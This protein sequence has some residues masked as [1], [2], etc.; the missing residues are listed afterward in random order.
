MINIF[1]IAGY[2]YGYCGEAFS[3]DPANNAPHAESEREDII[4][5]ERSK[6]YEC[7]G[8]PIV[9][10]AAFLSSKPCIIPFNIASFESE[11][12]VDMIGGTTKGSAIWLIKV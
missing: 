2:S 12:M 5:K 7:R 4:T 1:P 11:Q 9:Q 6:F 8:T 3:H 10:T